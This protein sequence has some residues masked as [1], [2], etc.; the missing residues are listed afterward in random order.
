MTELAIATIVLQ[1][2]TLFIS[3]GAPVVA[4]IGY[5][6][7]HIKRSSCCGGDVEFQEAKNSFKDTKGNIIEKEKKKKKKEKTED[8]DLLS[9]I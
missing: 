5:A 7:T 2:M 9:D 1:G 6:L 3:C 4:G 8:S